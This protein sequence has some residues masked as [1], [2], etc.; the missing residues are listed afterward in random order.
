[1]KVAQIVRRA[2][3][4]TATFYV[5]F[6]DVPEAVLA[7]I[8][9]LSQS[10]PNLLALVRQRWEGQGVID[11]AHEFV[12]SYIERCQRHAAVFR[13]RNLASDEGDARFTE[14]R[15]NAV[16]PL[17]SAIAGRVAERQA[18]GDLPGDLQPIAAAGALLAMIER[19][20]VVQLPQSGTT[21]TRPQLVDV[22]AFFA[23][24]LLGRKIWRRGENASDSTPYAP[25]SPARG[26]V[27][28]AA[29]ARELA[30]ELNLHGQAI[31]PK[32]AR[33]RQR[34]IEATN[35][36]MRTESLLD[37]SVAK[38]AK[39]GDTSTS[40]FYLYFK[41]V[42]EVVLAVIGQVGVS[43]PELLGLLAAGWEARAT[44]D[45]A[46]AFV[47]R[48]IATWQQN[49]ALFRVRNL[50]ADEGDQRFIRARINSA[51]PLIELL[52]RRIGEC[53]ARG[54]LPNDLH[55]ESAAGGCMAMIER[56]AATPNVNTESTV[57]LP[58]VSRAAAFF[59]SILLQG[60]PPAAYR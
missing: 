43:T 13:I 58:A 1:L 51:R 9:A 7:L 49:R 38:I 50:A 11:Q 42:S 41:D 60:L 14:L 48:Y 27:R 6:N 46:Y 39:A 23:S 18:S 19:I 24:V 52:E 25:A 15:I 56:L 21:V 3:T 32:G 4:S 33:T 28:P 55:P 20:A 40:T 30:H 44:D 2:K 16:W 5:Y 59:L 54:G 17:L 53:Q 10:P 31:G 8:G 12:G 29:P 37:L 26:P 34:L 35:A 47:S 22:A 45:R 57:T 36:L